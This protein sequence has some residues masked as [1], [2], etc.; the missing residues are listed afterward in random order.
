[1]VGSNP[2]TTSTAEHEHVHDHVN[3]H[4][5]VDV[6]VIGLFAYA[7]QFVDAGPS[8]EALPVR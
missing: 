7:P 8:D 4:V 3:V 2:R 1:M 5:L 6:V